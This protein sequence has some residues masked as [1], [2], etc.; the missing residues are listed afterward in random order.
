[1]ILD[2]TQVN[3]ALSTML[4]ML[5]IS[6]ISDD[7]LNELTHTVADMLEAFEEKNEEVDSP[8]SMP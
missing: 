2:R 4:A 1:M 6:R 3:D 8:A 7:D 5:N